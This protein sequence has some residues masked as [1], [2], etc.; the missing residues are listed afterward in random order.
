M[1]NDLAMEQHVEMLLRMSSG[2]HD[3]TTHGDI[4]QLSIWKLASQANFLSICLSVGYVSTYICLS[5]CLIVC[6]I[7]TSA[8]QRIPYLV[9]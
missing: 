3:A 6:F 7:K 9:N 4:F 5:T 8:D 1:G 2:G